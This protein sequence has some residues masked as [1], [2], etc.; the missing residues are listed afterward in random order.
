MSHPLGK[1][2]AKV[3]LRYR[4]HPVETF[5]ADG[6]DHA[7]ATEFARGL[8]IGVCNIFKPSVFIESIEREQ[9]QTQRRL[10]AVG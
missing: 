5:S 8:A 1:N 10:R 4:N 7:F 3:I 6:A 2:R 9:L